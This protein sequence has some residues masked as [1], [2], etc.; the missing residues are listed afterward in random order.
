LKRDWPSVPLRKIFEIAR[1][2]SPRPIQDYLTED[3]NGIN[4]I[5]ISD[6]TSSDKFIERTAKKIRQEGAKSSRR[7]Y[8]GDFLLTNS[9]SFGRPYILK[10]EGC[11]HDGWLHLSKREP[12]VDEGYFYHLLGSHLIYAKF[13]QL[14]AGAT[15]KNLN[16]D[17]VGAVT[18]PLPPLREQQRIAA[19]LDKTDS[20]RRKRQE[21]IRVADEFLRAVFIEVF[22]DPV[23]NSKHLPTKSIEE[24]CSVGTGATPSRERA[25]FFG[26]PYPWIKTGEVDSAW[27]THAEESISDRAIKE[28]NCKLF[29]ERTILVAMYGQGKTRG[30][31]GMLGI[32][33]AT[34]QACAAIL[35]SELIDPLFLY[36]QLTLMYEH[37]R[38]MGRGGNQENLN[39]GMIKSLQVLVPP[40][41]L[42]ERFLS[43]RR[44]THSI[45]EKAR[46]GEV[47]SQGLADSLGAALLA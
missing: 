45:L 27:I 11:I 4:W 21:A 14:A 39:L 33:A 47:Q 46:A 16:I 24:L 30:K 6:A 25:D 12:N 34:N 20:L 8:P 19:I 31:V 15:V 3:P 35:P 9:M 23:A 42:V 26:G 29:P 38:A 2:G 40:V 41:P 7:V 22:G 43:I 5:M 37:L 28:T 36:T 44:R 32:S 1:G 13:K 18:V 17:L 10:T